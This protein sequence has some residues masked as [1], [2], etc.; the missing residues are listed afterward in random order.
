MGRG[1]GPVGGLGVGAKWDRSWDFGFGGGWVGLG[2]WVGA[3]GWLPGWGGW[4]AC[5][6]CLLVAA[7]GRFGPGRVSRRPFGRNSAAR[8]QSGGARAVGRRVGAGWVGVGARWG[9]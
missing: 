1:R 7:K 8:E 2:G 4:A 3:G 6:G 9:A 5:V